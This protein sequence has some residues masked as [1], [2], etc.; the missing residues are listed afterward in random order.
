MTP[1]QEAQNKDYVGRALEVS[2]HVGLQPT[3]VRLVAMATR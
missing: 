2:I 1:E 3:D